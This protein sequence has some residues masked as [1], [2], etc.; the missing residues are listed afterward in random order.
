MKRSSDVSRAVLLAVG[1]PALAQNA[2]PPQPDGR[3]RSRTTGRTDTQPSPPPARPLHRRLRRPAAS[4]ASAS[5]DRTT[6]PATAK[7]P[8]PHQ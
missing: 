8:P 2:Q 5:L 6:K 1:A 7:Y 3:H 4:A